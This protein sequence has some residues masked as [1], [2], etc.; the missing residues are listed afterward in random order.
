[1]VR[2]PAWPCQHAPRRSKACVAHGRCPQVRPP[3][4]RGGGAAS[5]PPQRHER[6]QPRMS[7]CVG[8]GHWRWCECLLGLAS[9]PRG[10]HGLAWHI[11]GAL[12][13]VRRVSRAAEPLPHTPSGMSAASRARRRAWGVTTVDGASACLAL[14]ACPEAATGLR[15]TWPSG[16]STAC[17]G[18]WSRSRTHPAAP[19][20]ARVVVHG[21][22]SMVRVPAWPCQRAPRR[23]WSCVAP[24][25]CA[26]YAS[27]P[28]TTWCRT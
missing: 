1:M 18:R 9:I 26:R 3:R 10:G 27:S 6:R 28:C 8:G 7:S 25:R 17:P 13:R 15:G 12:R 22:W 20:A 16:A 5:A 24:G 21:V 2:V 11:A 4:V 14:P 19:P 23:P